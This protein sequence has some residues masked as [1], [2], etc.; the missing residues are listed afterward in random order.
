MVIKI[1]VNTLEV[2]LFLKEI[3]LSSFER[4]TNK[5]LDIIIS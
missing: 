2:L 5:Y 4:F 1:I 3:V